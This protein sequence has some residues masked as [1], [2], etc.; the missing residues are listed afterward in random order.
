MPTKISNNYVKES[1]RR[2]KRVAEYE[3][4]LQMTV[5]KIRSKEKYIKNNWDDLSERFVA[6]ERRRIHYMNRYCDFLANKLEK[7]RN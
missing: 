2:Q 3:R 5:H 6:D 7:N 1:N 4:E